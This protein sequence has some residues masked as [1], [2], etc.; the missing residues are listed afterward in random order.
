MS[1]TNSNI[2]RVTG[3][4]FSVLFPSN[5]TAGSNLNYQFTDNYEVQTVYLKVTTNAT[6]ANRQLRLYF[7]NGISETFTTSSFSFQTASTIVR[8]IMMQNKAETLNDST[9][10]LAGDR[11]L[12]KNGWRMLTGISGIQAGDQISDVAVIVRLLAP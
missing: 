5:P 2:S 11:V 4:D 10:M 9:I 12:V 7:T 8:Y 6:A 3:N 1:T